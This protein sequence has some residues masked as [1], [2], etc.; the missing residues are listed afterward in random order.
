MYIMVNA[1]NA[2]VNDVGNDDVGN[3]DDDD[4]D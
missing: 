4:D 3:D 1:M 2:Q